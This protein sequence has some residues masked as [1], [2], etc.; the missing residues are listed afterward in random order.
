MKQVHRLSALPVLLGLLALSGCGGGSSA[1]NTAS[2]NSLAGGGNNIVAMTVMPGPASNQPFNQPYVTVKICLPGSAT[3]SPVSDILVDTGSYG[4]RVMAS[5]LSAAGVNLPATPDPNP[6]APGNTIQE[7]LPFADGYAWGQ[8]SLAGVTVGGET[9]DGSVPIQVIDDSPSPMPAAPSGCAV[10]APLNSAEALGA[11]GILGVGVFTSDCG[12][13][14]AETPT[15]DKEIYYSCP[16]SGNCSTV[17]QAVTDQVSNPVAYF[18]TDNNGVVLQLPSISSNGA[19]TAAG[20]LVF[21]IGT[22]ANNGLGNATVLTANTSG[23]FT[24]SFN[25]QSL[26]DSFIDSGSNA[27]F[28][29]D[30][31]LAGDECHSNQFYCP[32]ATTQLSATN[33]GGNG[34]TSNISFSIISVDKIGNNYA[35]DDVAG[36]APA[37]SGFSSGYFDWGLPFFYGRTIYFALDGVEAG[38]TMGPYYAY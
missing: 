23:Y 31:S 21:G 34:V 14:C 29:N 22:E 38:G 13:Y 10:G 15:P 1:S 17:S 32:P 37:I 5:A 8:V 18:P 27:L 35:L 33:Q 3:C 24:T 20:Y 7:C 2:Q 26:P 19:P 4:L 11:N 30:P 16:A 9:T 36:P 12:S 28:F 25:G 6:L